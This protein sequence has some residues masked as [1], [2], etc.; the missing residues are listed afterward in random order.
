MSHLK[1]ALLLSALA[2]LLLS[3]GCAGSKPPQVITRLQ[4]E[5]V[6]IPPALLACLPDPEIPDNVMG[7][8][9]LA[10][11]LLSLWQ[12]GDDCRAKLAAVGEATR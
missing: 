3:T 7:D 9:E 12:A 11:Y 8:A 5:K 2:P 10:D 6:E 1:P 4:V